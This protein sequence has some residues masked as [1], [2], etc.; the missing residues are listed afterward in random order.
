MVEAVLNRDRKDP[1][2]RTAV[3]DAVR[4][5]LIAKARAGLLQ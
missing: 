5:A 2:F 3:D 1:A 4:I